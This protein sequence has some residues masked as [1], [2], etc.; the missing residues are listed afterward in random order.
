MKARIT[1]LFIF[2]AAI[3]LS[4]CSSTIATSNHVV[5]ACEQGIESLNARL[6][7]RNHN[8]HQANLSR[9]NAL[10]EAAQIQQ[11]FAEYPGCVEKLQRAKDYLNGQQAAIISRL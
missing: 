4:G 11:Q 6:N 5:T 9:A 10:F 1:F 3:S 2:A 7:A 8:I